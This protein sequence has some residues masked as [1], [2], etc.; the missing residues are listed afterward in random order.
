MKIGLWI[1]PE[2][3]SDNWVRM[4]LD[5][6]LDMLGLHPVGGNEARDSL[7]RMIDMLQNDRQF[8]KRIEELERHGVQVEYACHALSWM[9]P[10][11]YFES[12]PDWFRLNEDDIRVPDYNCCPSSRQALKVITERAALLTKYLYTDSHR[13]HFWA[14]DA[15]S[16]SC[17]CEE[18]RQYSPSDNLLRITHAVL[19]GIKQVDSLGKLSYLA[20]H[21]TINAPK[22]VEPLKDVFLEYAP[23]ERDYHKPLQDQTSEKNQRQHAA[24]PQ[25]LRCFGKSDSTVLD[26]WMD[27]SLFS[28]WKK[29]PKKFR[30]HEDVL[31]KDARMY[32]EYGFEHIT[33]F[34]CYLGDEYTS[35]HGEYPPV[36]G[37]AEIIRKLR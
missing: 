6:G 7:Q 35:E 10:R 12:H 20:Y 28:G 29:P 27:N 16:G 13:N 24:L 4:A 5:A 30:L 9:L 36:G 25:L 33:S 34:G 22:T 31:D 11:D 18:C 21:E 23:M 14:D 1:H 17:Y 2:E 3:L 37:Y 32:K 26:Y 19:E 15:A 8:N